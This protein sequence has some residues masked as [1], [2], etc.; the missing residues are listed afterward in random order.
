[1]TKARILAN[2]I[3]DGNTFADEA[4][5]V[6]EVTGAAPI[7]NPSFT[8]TVSSAGNVGIGTSSPA[9][10][11]HSLHPTSPKLTLERDST[12]LAN[13]NVI[14]EIA[15]AHKD[16]NDAGTAVRIIGRAE[17]TAGAAGLAFSTGTPTSTTERLRITSDG[18]VAFSGSS[19]TTGTIKGRGT[20]TV[21]DNH[22]GNT[23]GGVAFHYTGNGG[24]SET[25]VENNN[26][27]VLN[28][29]PT[30]AGSN[31]SI[32]FRVDDDLKMMLDSS[33]RLLIGNTDG[34]YASANADNVVIGDR[35]SSAESGFTFGSTVASSLRFADSAAI[36]QGIIQYVHNDTVNTDYMNFYTAGTER[37]RLENDGNLLLRSPDAT[38]ITTHSSPYLEFRA[39]QTNGQNVSLAKMRGYSPGAWGGDL[40]FETKPSNGQVN[41]TTVETMRINQAGRVTTPYQPAFKAYLQADL[42]MTNV[43]YYKVTHG[44]S[45]FN[46][47][48]HYSTSNTRFTAPV[49][50]TYFFYAHAILEGFGTSQTFRMTSQIRVNGNSGNKKGLASGG[51]A[52][53]VHDDNE[54]QVSGLIYLNANDYAEHY[55]STSGATDTTGKVWGQSTSMPWTSFGGYLLG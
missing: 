55:V 30:Q 43:G 14:G 18:D 20:V 26:T 31:T 3:S 37:M 17:G 53:S 40:I 6:T 2:F 33:G 9:S 10:I 34:S 19:G 15:M 28:A 4:I 16:S 11:I 35:T 23:G 50:G 22:G 24:Y 21:S 32:K 5:T 46:I 42:A 54:V 41:D 47:G 51:S 48:G 12:S 45:Q 39:G 7:A 49:A 29:D 13:N 38:G 25:Y 36:Q 1:M 8:G 44:G 52:N 27:L